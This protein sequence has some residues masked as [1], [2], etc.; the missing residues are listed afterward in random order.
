MMRRRLTAEEVRDMIDLDD[1]E[2]DIDSDYRHES[3]FESESE[4]DLAA[5]AGSSD[6]DDPV[7]HNAQPPQPAQNRGRL[8]GRRGGGRPRGAANRGNRAAA[9]RYLWIDDN[10]GFV[11]DDFSPN[12][13]CGPK[14]IPDNV[15]DDQ[16]SFLDWFSLLWPPELWQLLVDETNRQANRV[17]ATK[18]DH[19]YA[20]SYYPV[21][22]EEMKAFFGC[23]VVIEMLVHKTRYEH[24]WRQ[25][26]NDLTITPGFNRIFTRDRFLAIWSFLHCVNEDDP[27]LDKTD[28]IYKT[29]P[30]FNIVLEKF[31]HYYKPEQDLSLDEGMIPTKNSLS[32]RQYIKDKPVRWGI[33]SF[34]VC[35]SEN[36][37]ICNDEIYT[38]ARDDANAIDNLGVT[39][40]LVVRLL[41]PFTDQNYRVY[42]DRY[43]SGIE[44]A[45]YLKRQCGIGYVG[46]IQTN[47]AGFPKDIIKKKNQMARGESIMKNNGEVAC[48]TWRDSRPIYFLTSQFISDPPEHVQRYDAR[49]HRR[50]AVPSPK[51]VVMYNKYMGGT[52]K[53]DQM[54]R[55]HKSRR[56]YKWP[57]RL[58]IKFFMW[59]TYNTYVLIGFYR[60]HQ[61]DGMRT[62]TF[63]QFVE[64]LCNLLVG[65]FVRPVP[66]RPA[67]G[68]EE[69][70]FQNVGL[71]VVERP[72]HATQDNRCVVCSEKHRRARLQSPN[73]AY[74]DLPPRRKTVFWCSYCEKFLCIGTGNQNC[75]K[76]WHSKV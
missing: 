10:T 13:A 8:R 74:K 54:T 71:H 61:R 57:R 17:K 9:P 67:R 18:P 32:I 48:I 50:V 70:R 7:V 66:V 28:K 22:L 16:G 35:D 6:S 37:Y 33:K 41:R 58:M 43:Y 34:L 44:L 31:Q 25:K 64:K 23:R 11:D 73:R 56:H 60:P 49:E 55:L 15:T 53:N 21:T 72:A 59:A 39:G 38:G 2:D 12:E 20:K 40:N 65:D 24:Y 51:A 52:D 76:D 75:W 5:N 62:Q 68:N 29:R 63:L 42:C 27:E 1:D 3:D 14:N 46:T 47:R 45:Q 26:D 19:Y 4:P 30:I 36:G 69:R